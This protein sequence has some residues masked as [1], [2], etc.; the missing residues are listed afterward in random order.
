[1]TSKTSISGPLMDFRFKPAAFVHFRD[2]A[3]LDRVRR[4]P[5]SE[6]AKHPNPDFRITVMPDSEIEFVWLEDMFFRIKS[7][8]DRNEKLVM[9]LP[10]PYPGFARL[11]R[12]INRFRVDCRQVH[13]FAMDE[14]A[15]E[16]KELA[17]ESWP[18]S[19]VG[20]M[21]RYLWNEIDEQL[22]PPA[23][24]FHGPTTR[25]IHGDYGK[26][27][28]DHGNAD[29]VY[30]GPGWSGHLC[31]IEPDAPEFLGDL[32]SWKRMGSR[33]CTLSPFSVAQQALHGA[34]GLSGD[35]AA[36]PSKGATVGPAQI[37]AAKNRVDMHA[38][39][40][41]GTA[42]TWQRLISRLSLHGPVTPQVPTSILQ[43]LR[44]D[45]WITETLA[46]DI[47][48]DWQKGY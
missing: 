24:H 9:L 35:V 12:L 16:E 5:R 30:T 15:N 42:T 2:T 26:S 32:E 38:L 47:K 36:V 39:T 23:S 21:R 10:N 19:L 3:E 31:F 1:M 17:P 18:Q 45:V 20:A 7:A 8:S 43:T 13:F 46:A 4:I 28:E 41:H 25:N 14:F 40:V 11:A 34:F 6:I 44:T 48:A 33:V 37:I 29:I 22:R 27:L